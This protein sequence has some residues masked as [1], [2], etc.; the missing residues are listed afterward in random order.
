MLQA[1]NITISIEHM[2]CSSR[3]GWRRRTSRRAYGHVRA[4]RD[5]QPDDVHVREHEAVAELQD[6]GLEPVPASAAEQG[7]KVRVGRP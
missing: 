2:G 7:L 4:Q 5:A 1:I 3:R 6:A